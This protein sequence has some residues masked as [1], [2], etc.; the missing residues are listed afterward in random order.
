MGRCKLTFLT[1]PSTAAL[2]CKWTHLTPDIDVQWEKVLQ[3]SKMNKI[4]K[5]I[6]KAFKNILW[7]AKETQKDWVSAKTLNYRL[8]KTPASYEDDAK[9][10]MNNNPLT[11]TISNLYCLFNWTE[12][13]G[14]YLFISWKLFKLWTFYFIVSLNKIQCLGFFQEL[15]RWNQL[16]MDCNISMHFKILYFE[17]RSLNPSL[18]PPPCPPLKFAKIEYQ[19]DILK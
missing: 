10:H 8:H 7:K 3:Y 9:P 14:N 18:S 16:R 12:I 6:M 19:K 1:W 15:I 11:E 4:P 2:L 13:S 17:P 5:R